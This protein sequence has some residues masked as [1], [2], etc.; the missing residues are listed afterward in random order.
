MSKVNMETTTINKTDSYLIFKIGKE[1]FALSVYEVINILEM[2]PITEVPQAP[3]FL[4]GVINLRGEVLPLIDPKKR[5][6]LPDQEQTRNTC[7][8]VLEIQTEEE[9]IKLGMLV[10]EVN[11]VSEYNQES[12]LDSPSIGSTFRS[13]IIKGVIRLE[14]HFIM[15]LNTSLLFSIEEINDI[16]N[17]TNITNP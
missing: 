10:D 13:E 5:L 17:S 16:Y 7:I 14:E 3:E 2:I 1:S 8:L 12:I 4:L 9:K 6:N 11:E 15:L